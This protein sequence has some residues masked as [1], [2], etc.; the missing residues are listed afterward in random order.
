MRTCHL[1]QRG[2]VGALGELDEGH[3]V[4]EVTDAGEGQDKLLT[5]QQGPD[6]LLRLGHRA[7]R[8]VPAERRPAA[9][10]LPPRPTHK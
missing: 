8:P 5:P 4:P 7:P 10:A 3:L 2:D 9:L 1:C 6:R